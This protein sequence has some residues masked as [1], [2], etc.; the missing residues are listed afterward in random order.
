MLS[1]ARYKSFVNTRVLLAFVVSFSFLLTACVPAVPTITKLNNKKKEGPDKSKKMS[2][3]S[4]AGVTTSGTIKI[5]FNI[6]YAPGDFAGA[7]VATSGSTKI[8]V[9]SAGVLNGQ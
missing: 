6:G 3:A 8:R 4:A 9:S 7:P 2:L 1:R 5:K